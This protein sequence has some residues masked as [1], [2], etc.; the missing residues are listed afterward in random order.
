MKERICGGK[1]VTQSLKPFF[2]VDVHLDV[3]TDC[4]KICFEKP[5]L[6]EVQSS[7]NRAA[8]HVLKSTKFVEMWN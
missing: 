2:E 4:K 7:I 1:N 8:S 6:F 5:S 3:E